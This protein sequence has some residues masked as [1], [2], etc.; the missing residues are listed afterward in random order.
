MKRKMK[1]TAATL[2]AALAVM[3]G[4]C[5]SD[6]TESYVDLRSRSIP[7]DT[8]IVY[9]GEVEPNHD[10]YVLYYADPRPEE[11][12]ENRVLRI[13]YRKWSYEEIPCDGINPHSVDRAGRSMKFLIRTQNSYSFDIVDFND[14]SVV[15]VD[16]NHTHAKDGTE[17]Y[18]KPRAIGGYN[19]KYKI[20]LLSVKNR[21]AAD[22]IDVTAVQRGESDPSRVILTVLGDN[23]TTVDSGSATG[24]SL[25][26]DEDHCGVIDRVNHLIWVYRV[27]RNETTDELTFTLTQKFDMGV[28]IHALE[29]ID[30][31]H[32]EEEIRLFYATIEGDATRKPALPPAI[33]EIRFDPF[34]ETLTKT[35]RVEFPESTQIVEVEEN[36][37]TYVI[38]PI[39]HHLAISPDGRYIIVPDY[40]GSVY[41]VDRDTFTVVKKLDAGLG[42]AHVNF[43]ARYD[44]AVVTSHFDRYVTIIDMKNLTVKKDVYITEQHYHGHLLQPH[45]SYIDPDGRYFYTFS[46]QDGDFVKIDLVTG[47]VVDRL[48]TGGA[49]EQAHS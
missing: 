43:D 42:A 47:E 23:N 17:L 4:G 41:I 26:F 22:V 24:H 33:E 14:Y 38:K 49:P 5:G 3:M 10:A 7:I 32:S 29:R 35:R 11:N 1:L 30:D 9:A 27:D 16:M 12:G 45:F 37:E 39:T 6:D 2:L 36:N 21:P 20:Q 18:H 13:D 15:T 48:H 40:D 8:N 19:D 44:L 25:W 46:T 28:S 34:E 31:A